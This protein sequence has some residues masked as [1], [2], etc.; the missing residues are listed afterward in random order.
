MGWRK[1]PG[2]SC[3]HGISLVKTVRKEG[4]LSLFLFFTRASTHRAK[5]LGQVNAVE[6]VM[7]RVLALLGRAACPKGE[8]LT[9]ERER[10]RERR[11]EKPQLKV[12][13]QSS[14]SSGSGS[15]RSSRVMRLDVRPCR[16]KSKDA[17]CDRVP[18]RNV[19]TSN[20]TFR[21]SLNNTTTT[22]F[23]SADDLSAHLISDAHVTQ[24]STTNTQD[25]KE[26]E[27]SFT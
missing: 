7:G 1:R 19:V 14:S 18:T 9:T 15:K 23:D 2:E 25:G 20:G 10:E 4:N 8:N 11:E 17:V 16:S 6:N 5:E 22:L 24:Y 12:N 27:H 26:N 21:H 13:H 3:T